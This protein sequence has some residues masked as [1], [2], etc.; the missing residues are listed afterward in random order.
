MHQVN[1][2]V[3][4]NIF[5]VRRAKM[6]V[7][8]LTGSYTLQANRARFNQFSVNPQCPLCKQEPETR[9][10]FIVTCKSWKDIRI[11][12]LRKIRHLFGCSS[13]IDHVLRTPELCVQLLL[14]SSH[15]CVSQYL[16]ITG[17]QTELLELRSR[18][19]IY[20]LHLKRSRILNT[21]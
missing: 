3:K 4:N 20:E 10:H 18:E 11:S 8:L 12:N 5:D 9:E 16:D 2:Y 17:R 19:L 6:K 7:R 13:N 15:P 14:D 1:A 21:E